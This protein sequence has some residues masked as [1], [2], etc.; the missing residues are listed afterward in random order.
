MPA[1]PPRGGLAADPGDG[2]AAICRTDTD[3]AGTGLF[4][5]AGVTAHVGGLFRCTV[6]WPDV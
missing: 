1:Q 2:V 3:G 4:H 5:P 6:P